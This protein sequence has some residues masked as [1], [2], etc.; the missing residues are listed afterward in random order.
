[1]ADR[2]RPDRWEGLSCL[3]IW[4]RM[5]RYQ[6]LLVR[7]HPGNERPVR[8]CP[9]PD[10]RRAALDQIL[11]KLYWSFRL[12]IAS[13]NTRK[14]TTC[15]RISQQRNASN[16]SNINSTNW[17]GR[18]TS[19]RSLTGERHWLFHCDHRWP[20][21]NSRGRRARG[22]KFTFVA[23]PRNEWIGAN[24]W[25]INT[26]NTVYIRNPALPHRN[27]CTS[28]RGARTEYPNPQQTGLAISQQI[29][30]HHRS[31][32]KWWRWCMIMMDASDTD[33]AVDETV[34]MWLLLT[35][36]II[37]LSQTNG[38][39]DSP[40]L[41]CSRICPWIANLFFWFDILIRN[42]SKM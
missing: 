27:T 32:R 28:P 39:C 9:I 20:C 1:M 7:Y 6:S 34:A 14:R 12:T 23:L 36:F 35:C 10:F 31:R 37:C 11:S 4:Q 3:R 21:W 2:Y 30:Q 33:F 26:Y 24:A 15:R 42:C 5:S 17:I 40:G 16:I 18:G 29:C 38:N 25:G 41:N 19:P 13:P 22:D 8:S